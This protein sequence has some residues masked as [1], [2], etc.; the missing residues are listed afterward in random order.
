MGGTGVSEYGSVSVMMA[1]FSTGMIFAQIGIPNGI[2]R[3]VAYYLGRD[4]KYKAIGSFQTGLAL[5]T[6][7]SVI[8]G[9]ILFV[10]APWLANSIFQNSKLT[11]LIRMAAVALPFRAYASSTMSL[12]SALG[13]M[14]YAVIND[15][16]FV[17]LTQ[18]VL[19]ALL[20]RAGFGY[21]GAAFA[22]AFTFAIGAFIGIYFAYKEFPELFTKLSEFRNTKKIIHHSSPLVLAGLFSSITGNLDTFM[23]Q[24]FMSSENVGIYQ[25]AFPFAS[26]LIIGS[27]MFGSIFLSNASELISKGKNKALTSTYRTIVKWTAIITIPAFLVLMAFPKTVL[28]LFGSEYYSAAGALRILSLGFFAKAITGPAGNIYQAVERTNLNFYTSAAVGISNLILN[29]L[30]IPRLGIVGAAWASTGSL[31]IAAIMNFIIV[32]Q[33]IGKSLFKKSLFKILI[34]GLLAISSIYILS[35]SLFK[36]VPAWFFPVDLVLFGLIYTILIL[37]LRTIEHNDKIIIEGLQEKT[38]LDL[39]RVDNLIDKFSS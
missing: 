19:A 3:F 28:I 27:S 22:Y 5:I 31:T 34:S 39:D 10:S 14:R 36:T 23:I 29:L 4:E 8:T 13:K 21:I 1:I 7:S 33:V 17:N 18:L 35:N 37:G 25:A 20:I 12:T 16:I 26:A 32:Y 9:T 11:L 24:S 38:G 2:Q 30:L 6:A 15:K